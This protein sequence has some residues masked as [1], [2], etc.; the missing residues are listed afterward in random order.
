MK[1]QD[2]TE[3]CK[4]LYNLIAN[5]EILIG[6]FINFSASSIITKIALCYHNV[7]QRILGSNTLL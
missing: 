4:M 3:F 1:K 5:Y 7:N 2:V 6:F